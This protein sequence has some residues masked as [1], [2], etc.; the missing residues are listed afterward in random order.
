MMRPFRF[1]SSPKSDAVKVLVLRKGKQTY[2]AEWNWQTPIKTALLFLENGSF[3]IVKM[4]R[5][6]FEAIPHDQ[7][8]LE[9]FT[10]QHQI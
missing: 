6:E 9:V 8:A 7:N 3:E 5:A 4:S 1:L 2:Y 10:P